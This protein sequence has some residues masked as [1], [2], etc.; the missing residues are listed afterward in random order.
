LA[1]FGWREEDWWENMPWLNPSC[2]NLPLTTNIHGGNKIGKL[3]T[4]LVMNSVGV[5]TITMIGAIAEAVTAVNGIPN[6]ELLCIARK[7]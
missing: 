3:R 1:L 4:L 2:P 5:P 6:Q 7:T